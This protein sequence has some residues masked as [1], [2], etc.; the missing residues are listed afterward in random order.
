MMYKIIGDIPGSLILVIHS[1][2]DDK[3]DKLQEFCKITESFSGDRT[4]FLETI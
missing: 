2:L 3:H 4:F 1:T